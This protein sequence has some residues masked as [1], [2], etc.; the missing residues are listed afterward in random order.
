M[1][2][3]AVG[4]P[5]HLDMATIN[6]TRP[7]CARVKI[8]DDLQAYLPKLVKMEIQDEG[9]G[10]IREEKVKIQYD[11]IPKYCSKCKLQGHHEEE[12]RYLHLKLTK[13]QSEEG[14]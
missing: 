8:L 3:S 6:K 1:I 11:Y 14:R 5:L 4:K 10:G 12:Y 7:S 13:I 9:T 2:A